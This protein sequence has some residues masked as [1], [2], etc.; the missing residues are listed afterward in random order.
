LWI[1]L[2]YYERR[3]EIIG[4]QGNRLS[5][6]NSPQNGNTASLKSPSSFSRL[7]WPAL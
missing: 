6:L 4:K 7:Q 2:F 5:L 1:L 3:F